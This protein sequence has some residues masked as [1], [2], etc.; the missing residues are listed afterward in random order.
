MK[1]ITYRRL[2]YYI[3][4]SSFIQSTKDRFYIIKIKDNKITFSQNIDNI[5][6]TQRL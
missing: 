1:L 2:R 6:N 4:T 5:G 3:N